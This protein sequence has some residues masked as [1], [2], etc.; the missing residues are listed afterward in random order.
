[1]DNN[2]LT[3]SV[4]DWNEGDFDFINYDEDKKYSSIL[5]WGM[6]RDSEPVL[7]RFEKFPAT[8]YIELPF[9]LTNRNKIIWNNNS[10]ENLFKKLQEYLKDDKPKKYKF[11]NKRKLYYYRE[12]NKSFPMIFI[13]FDNLKS[14]HHCKNFLKKEIYIPNLGNM[15]LTV[16]ESNISLVRKMLTLKRCRYSQWFTIKGRK[17]LDYEKISHL[18]EEYIVDFRTLNPLSQELTKEWITYPKI[19]C[20][21]IEC[22]SDNH[23]IFPDKSSAKHVAYMISCIFQKIS[24]PET[25]KRF[26]IILGDCN[27]VE[28]VEIIRVNSEKELCDKFIDLISELDPEIIS[29]YNIYGFDYPYLDTRLKRKLQTWKNNGNRIINTKSDLYSKIW[30]SSGYGYNEINYLNFYGRISI[31]MY[32]YIKRDYKLPKYNLE[33]VAKFFINRGKHDI[34]AVDMFKIYEKT[35]LAKKIDFY[36]KKNLQDI[37][38]FVIEEASNFIISSKEEMT[39]VALYCIEDSELVI[40][41]FEKINTWIGLVELSNIVGVNIIDLI[42]RGQQIRGISQIY[43]ICSRNGYVI[44]EKI[45]ENNKYSGAFVFEP[46]PGLY[47]NV[48]C[49]DFK[50]LYPSIII[51]KNICYTTLIPPELYNTIP[52]EDCNII[53]WNEESEED[54]NDHKKTNIVTYKYKFI[55]REKKIGILPE[56]VQNL[57]N[58]RNQTRKQTKQE[59]DNLILTIL[60]KRQLALKISANSIYG[61]LGVTIGGKL[62][63]IEGAACITATGRQLIGQCKDYLMEKYKACITYGDT[64]SVLFS[65]P[66]IKNGKETLEWGKKLEKE[67][68]AIF[69]DPLY[70]EFEKAG[71]MFCI[72]KKKYVFWTYDKDGNLSDIENGIIMKG[73][74]LA[75][76]DN[77]K[78]QRYVYHKIL[79]NILKRKEMRETLDEIIRECL[80]LLNSKVDWK[81]LLIIRE[82]GFSYKSETFYMHIF[83]NEL[84]RL[85]I[86]VNPGERLE[87]LIVKGKPEYLPKEKNIDSTLL[88][89][90]IRT[91]EIFAERLKSENPEE[92]DYKYYINNL[93]KNMIEQLW[94]TGFS[95]EL[96]K[97]ENFNKINDY[98]LI[99][100]DLFK[101]GYVDSLKYDSIEKVNELLNSENKIKIKKIY[102]K[103]TSGKYIINYRITK[104]PIELLLKSIEYNQIKEF[105][106]GVGS[107]E[108]YYDL[109]PPK[110][111]LS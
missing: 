76:R 99:L 51:A 74:I 15:R 54:T 77:C 57:I 16:L 100:N 80:N 70:L 7:L 22:Y 59:T 31:D 6:N 38:P 60:D 61:M 86:P 109:Y 102:N 79:L 85:G 41:I 30:N 101:Q 48:I 81:D 75:R 58:E 4:Y 73:I 71:R 34:S 107:R 5:S 36:V 78:W 53:E 32:P 14:L 62:P 44:D 94:Y 111:I 89:Y 19:L 72:K 45:V 110:L 11:F 42:T 27:D 35:I 23:K 82:L 47:D 37:N 92:I 49:L 9:Y 43:D 66:N 28:D 67:I 56:L 12:E 63:L 106:K 26:L 108:L 8:C 21:D 17:V 87:Y 50:S 105:I 64:D 25:R 93:L 88:G 69:P 90:N 103:Y 52:D 3:V 13:I 1:M 39:K 40:D 2:E 33:T 98:N 97:I 18:K 29:G 95:K 10:I 68:S 46:N 55:K 65:L 91:P 96:E 83:S 20:F 84:K 24:H 104:N